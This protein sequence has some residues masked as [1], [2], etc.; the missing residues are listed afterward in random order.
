MGVTLLPVLCLICWHLLSIDSGLRTVAYKCTADVRKMLSDWKSVGNRLE[1]FQCAMG[2]LSIF[3]GTFVPK[4]RDICPD[5]FGTFA[6]KRG[7]RM[8]QGWDMDST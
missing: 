8:G 4:T 7:T 1:D 5:I 2:H 6:D 3:C